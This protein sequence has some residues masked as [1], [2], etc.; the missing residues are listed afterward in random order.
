MPRVDVRDLDE[1]TIH[2]LN[3]MAAEKK[4]SREELCRRILKDASLEVELKSQE[5]KYQALIE[6]LLDVIRQNTDIMERFE[7]RMSLLLEKEENEKI[8]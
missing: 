5:N 8:I 4:V 6:T 7:Y 3:Q 2:R 1:A